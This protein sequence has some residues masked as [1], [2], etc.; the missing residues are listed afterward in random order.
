LNCASCTS[1]DVWRCAASSVAHAGA[2]LRLP[3]RKVNPDGEHQHVVGAAEV[4]PVHTDIA[5]LYAQPVF[6]KKLLIHQIA[7]V[8]AALDLRFHTFDLRT[9]L[10]GN[11][12]Q[13]LV[14]NVS[15]GWWRS[16]RQAQRRIGAAVQELVQLGFE[17]GFLL[18]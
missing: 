2:I 12:K 8:L 5:V 9:I 7:L 15:P 10:V 18:L 11:G 13:R 17:H 4:G 1:N 14:L 3:D 6:R 16:H